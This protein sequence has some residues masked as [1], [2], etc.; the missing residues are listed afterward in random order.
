MR[1]VRQTLVA[2]GDGESC[3]VVASVVVGLVV[4]IAP[5][6]P[7]ILVD[8]L[9][10]DGGHLDILQSAGD[11]LNVPVDEAEGRAAAVGT[12][13][14]MD[15]APSRRSAAAGVGLAVVAPG[16]REH[17][18]LRGFADLAEE[19]EGGQGAVVDV[20]LL[21]GTV[22]FEAFDPLVVV[23]LAVGDDHAVAGILLTGLVIRAPGVFGTLI[24]PCVLCPVDAVNAFGFADQFGEDAGRV[25]SP[26]PGGL[27]A[28]LDG[29]VVV[30][31]NAVGDEAE[32][33]L[34]E[35][36][37]AGDSTGLLARLGER[38]QQHGSQDR[39]DGDYDEQFNEGKGLFHVVL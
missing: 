31:V 9:A 16:I 15:G 25:V 13:D 17:E 12:D 39:D 10:L 14:V 36:V 34:L 23:V 11:G 18:I 3:S 4:S 5:A 19:E 2:I 32:H 26:D 38:R 8:G 6:T 21:P 29:P 28:T 30:G 35:I 7:G 33:H 24:K 22:D 1:I 37:G 27:V 20:N